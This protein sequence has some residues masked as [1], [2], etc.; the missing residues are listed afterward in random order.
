M[1]TV[2]EMLQSPFGQKASEV[3]ATQGKEID[4]E[5]ILEQF[6]SAANIKNRDQVIRPLTT[7][8][9]IDSESDI[10]EDFNPDMIEDPILKQ[11]MLGGY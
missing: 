2:I 3:L 1:E 8:Q 7:P 6:L 10:A 5:L 9:E 4:Y 11:A